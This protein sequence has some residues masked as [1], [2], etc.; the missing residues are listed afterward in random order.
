MKIERAAER[1][2]AETKRELTKN[3]VASLPPGIRAL[4][5]DDD[6]R[7]QA[8]P[9]DD[10]DDD[11]DGE[12]DEGDDDGEP[13]AE[14]WIFST[15]GQPEENLACAAGAYRADGDDLCIVAQHRK[16]GV[17]F[18][19]LFEDLED[20]CEENNSDPDDFKVYDTERKIMALE[21]DQ[22][23]IAEI[24]KDATHNPDLDR[25]RSE[26][27]QF[28]WNQDSRGTEVITLPGIDAPMYRIGTA[29]RVEYTARK[30]GDVADYYH[31]HGEESGTF[32]TIYAVKLGDKFNAYLVVGGNME[33]RPEGITD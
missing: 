14:Y 7:K 2:I 15:P 4:V 22:Q 10:D 6:E 32:P 16:T 27:E 30:D 21:Y 33:I 5:G 20:W 26:H 9:D 13:C 18:M 8:D 23:T 11:D 19:G 29:K 31:D 17:A 3:A 1:L 25:A 24:L 12:G 28:H